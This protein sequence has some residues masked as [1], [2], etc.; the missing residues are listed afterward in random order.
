MS[1][2]TVRSSVAPPVS[3]ALDFRGHGG[4][5]AAPTSFG[6]REVE[7]VAGALAWLGERGI[8]RVA[9]VGLSLGGVTAIASVAVLGDGS[10]PGVDADPAAAARVAAPRRP[11]IVAV[12]ADSVAAGTRRPG[13]VAVA[14]AGAAVRGGP[15]ARWRRPVARR[16][17]TRDRARIR[18][19]GLLEG[20]PLLLI[21]G[22]A[23][24]TV[25]IADARRLAAVAPAGT[26]HWIV[27][28][29][30]TAARTRPT[31][32]GL[33]SAGHGRTCVPA[34]ASNARGAAL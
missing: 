10:L 31:R 30:D 24:T 27:P 28:G 2:S 29:R 21:S 16:R 19:V 4:S 3:S 15:P 9:I 6:L 13:R 17:S 12:V 18:V 5:D 25:P 26:E 14:R 33:R 11:R 1:W 7:D 34:F 23:D 8:E 20:T 22:D 32:C